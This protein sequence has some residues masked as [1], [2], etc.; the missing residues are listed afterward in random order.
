EA[1]GLAFEPHAPAGYAAGVA[2]YDAWIAALESG[3]V[4]P[5]GHAYAA[6]L[7]AEARR[8]A[9]TFT[10]VDDYGRVAA[11]LGELAERFPFP[12]QRPL[13]NAQLGG[14][15]ALLKRARESEARALSALSKTLV[16]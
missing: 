10:G 16:A 2:A 13:D 9:A 4:D 6:Q 14:A 1:L 8:H 5:A 3:H 11:A 7:A 15:A 12:P